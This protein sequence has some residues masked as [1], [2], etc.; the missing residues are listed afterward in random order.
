MANAH[1]FLRAGR[2]AAIALLAV[3]VLLPTASLGAAASG[4]S[5]GVGAAAQ[6][7]QS[8]TTVTWNGANVATASSASSALS[9]GFNAA[10]DV[11]FRW[12]PTTFPGVTTAR[13]AM[14]YFGFALSTRDVPPIA[15]GGG[16][17][18]SAVMNWTVG[19]IQYV[20]EGTYGITASLIASNG[21]TLWSENFYVRLTAPGSIAAALPIILLLIAVY[22]LYNVARSGRYIRL[23][24]KTKPSP[25]PSS[26]SP[27]PAAEAG[28]GDGP[29]PTAAPGE[30]PPGGTS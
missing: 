16:P 20:I 14:V 5:P 21:S 27:P 13:L 22:E 30:E 6:P 12:S 26:G 23:S 25:P 17:S 10:A 7:E 15:N 19:A 29:G 18:D 9:I 3:I 28:P 24:T 2:L 1:P 4:V 11:Q 8:A